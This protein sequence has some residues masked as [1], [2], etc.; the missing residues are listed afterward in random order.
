MVA[1][2]GGNIWGRGNNPKGDND[3]RKGL[4]VISALYWCP[5][6]RK[7]NEKV[8]RGGKGRAAFGCIEIR[9]EGGGGGRNL[10]K[11]KRTPE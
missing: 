4:S 5:G 1:Y 9:F 7:W 3:E 10:K 6:N 8:R 11:T 2:K